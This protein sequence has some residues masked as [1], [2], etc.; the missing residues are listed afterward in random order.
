MHW[1]LQHGAGISARYHGIRTWQMGMPSCALPEIVRRITMYR[2]CL[3]RQASVTPVGAFG[4]SVKVSAHTCA[5]TST[6]AHRYYTGCKRI[7]R[8]TI[9]QGCA[10]L[11][12]LRDEWSI[13]AK[14]AF[15]VWLYGV[16]PHTCF[17]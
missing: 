5:A 7:G 1:S 15:A 14:A 8:D 13:H 6:P 3:P 4:C 16:P 11:Y 12:Y 17:H 9:R 10:I 2:A